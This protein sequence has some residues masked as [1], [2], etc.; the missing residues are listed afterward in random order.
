MTI[1]VAIYM[2][3]FRYVIMSGEISNFSIYTKIKSP[4][5]F[6]KTHVTRNIVLFSSAVPPDSGAFQMLTRPS[7][8]SAASSTLRGG[9]ANLETLQ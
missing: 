4:H 5:H 2:I 3:Y 6:F 9:R 8:V 1:H 7:S